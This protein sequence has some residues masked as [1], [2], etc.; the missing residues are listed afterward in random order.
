MPKSKKIPGT[1]HPLQWY[2]DRIGKRIKRVHGCG[3]KCK[4]ESC[5][6]SRTTGLIVH[7]KLFAEYLFV[8]QEEQKYRYDDMELQVINAK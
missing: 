7:N 1:K 5:K 4:H 6:E 2:I 8:M 3:V